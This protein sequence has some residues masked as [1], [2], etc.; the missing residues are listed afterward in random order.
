MLR[1]PVVALAVM[2]RIAQ[3]HLSTVHRGVPLEGSQRTV[4]SGCLRQHCKPS[5]RGAAGE[6]C[7][8]PPQ[9][10]GYVF[11]WTPTALSTVFSPGH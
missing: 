4:H 3:V 6:Q 7:W 5:E 9:R 8:V 1:P 11:P 2:F 10:A